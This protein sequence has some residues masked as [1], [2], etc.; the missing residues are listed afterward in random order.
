M[1]TLPVRG[2]ATQSKDDRNSTQIQFPRPRRVSN[3]LNTS[4][5]SSTQ[6][7]WQ[8]E[9]LS[10]L[11]TDKD[12]LEQVNTMISDLLAERDRKYSILKDKYEQNLR[13]QKAALGAPC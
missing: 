9:R 6:N 12:I 7:L 3:V 4:Q 8:A 1:R 10:T 2:K 13:S 5:M 11:I